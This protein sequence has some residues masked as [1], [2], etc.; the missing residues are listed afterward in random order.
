MA[1]PIQL[2]SQRHD[3]FALSVDGNVPHTLPGHVVHVHGEA[4]VGGLGRLF[5]D[6][7]PVAERPRHVVTVIQVMGRIA[8]RAGRR[9]CR[10]CGGSVR[11]LGPDRQPIACTVADTEGSHVTS[12]FFQAVVLVQVHEHVGRRIDELRRDVDFQPLPGRDRERA[13][14]WREVPLVPKRHSPRL[15]QRLPVGCGEVEVVQAQVQL[16]VHAHVSRPVVQQELEWTHVEVQHWQHVQFA[17]KNALQACAS[18]GELLPREQHLA[19]VLKSIG[20]LVQHG[21]RVSFPSR[22]RPLRR[23]LGRGRFR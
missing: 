14:F 8:C 1:D 22:F 12:F 21:R 11:R 16:R 5:A 7:A 2:G 23:R 6:R 10:R 4:V 17:D 15:H 13:A 18:H 3:V 19:V 20:Q 9:R